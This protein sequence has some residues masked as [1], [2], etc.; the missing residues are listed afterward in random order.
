MILH[1]QAHTVREVQV[2]IINHFADMNSSSSSAS[3]S[4]QLFTQCDCITVRN[5]SYLS[6]VNGFCSVQY[7]TRLTEHILTAQQT[8]VYIRDICLWMFL[9]FSKFLTSYVTNFKLGNNH[10][11]TNEKFKSPKQLFPISF[12]L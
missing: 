7:K 1:V 3:L 5:H 6:S 11:C 9:P 4:I 2:E 8:P 10:C 12:L